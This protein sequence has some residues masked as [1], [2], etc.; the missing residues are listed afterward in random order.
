MIL[1]ARCFDELNNSTDLPLQENIIIVVKI[2]A[3]VK[4]REVVKIVSTL[5][6]HLTLI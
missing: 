6:P 4:I 5:P 2:R 3:V 1:C